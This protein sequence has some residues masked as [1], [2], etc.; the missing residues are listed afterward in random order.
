MTVPSKSSLHQGSKITAESKRTIPSFH[1]Y[2][3]TEVKEEKKGMEEGRKAMRERERE[4]RGEG[5]RPREKERK[6][7]HKTSKAVDKYSEKPATSR[8]MF[9]SVV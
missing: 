3:G 1:Q 6:K 2:C 5:G 8:N 4:D 9:P 7:R